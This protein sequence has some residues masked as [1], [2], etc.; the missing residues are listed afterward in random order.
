MKSYSLALLF[1]LFLL[2]GLGQNIPEINHWFFG[3]H[4]ALDFSSGV[5]VSVQNSQL[6][7]ME[8]T[9]SISDSVGNLLFYTD[10]ITVWNRLHGMMPNG[11]NLM[12][13]P[14][15]SQSALI[16]Q[17]PCY[18]NRYYIFTAPA[19]GSNKLYYSEVDLALN[20]GLGAVT[21]VKNIPLGT[22]L[23]SE[24]LAVVWHTDEQRLWLICQE[25]WLTNRFFAY[26]ISSSG[27]D[28]IPVESIAGINENVGV[29]YLKA[30]PKGDILVS[31]NFKSSNILSFNRTTGTV[32]DK[33]VIPRD[34][35]PINNLIG[36][37]LFYGAEFSPNGNLL[38]LTTLD[39]NIY[40]FDLTQLTALDVIESMVIIGSI[41]PTLET[42]AS[43]L[44]IGPDGKIYVAKTGTSSLARIENPDAI[45]ISC[46]F[47][48]N[49][50]Q[51]SGGC[52][53]GL[54]SF[55]MCYRYNF[56]ECP[57]IPPTPIPEVSLEIPNIITPN[58]DGLN[59]VF[60]IKNMSLGQVSLT[61]AN[62]WG[63]TIFFSDAYMNDWNGEAYSDGVYF[64]HIYDSKNQKTHT[65]F[66]EIIR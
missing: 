45:G 65:G 55:Q 37:D 47:T 27:V 36:A 15:T 7:T 19:G 62:R 30:N 31:C 44:Q 56:D 25:P 8:G 52:A 32:S 20:S 26:L 3:D 12:G 49:A 29:G 9:S 39:T 50:V 53:S 11:Q 24:K 16:V 54:P 5:P 1:F 28:S 40:Q 2:K 4:A 63:N 42:N 13:H 14:S 21:A 17:R 57:Y 41:F 60:L 18:P 64:Y 66:L 23:I 58:S 51:L 38:Y 48:E 33:F 35:V 34:S 6:N 10:G 46:G 43:A 59:D 22:T 61:I